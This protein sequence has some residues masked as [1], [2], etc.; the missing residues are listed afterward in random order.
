[1]RIFYLLIC[2]CFLQLF[3]PVECPAETVVHTTNISSFKSKV[4]AGNDQADLQIEKTVNVSQRIQ[5][6]L[7]PVAFFSYRF[8]PVAASSTSAVIFSGILPATHF[9][10][11][12]HHFW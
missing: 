1:M 3:S 11:P 9:I 4:F 12:K 5:H 10:C 2:F 8:L 7:F 6:D